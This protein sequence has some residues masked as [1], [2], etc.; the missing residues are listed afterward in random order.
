MARSS[1][2]RAQPAF[3]SW[4]GTVPYLTRAAIF[5]TLRSIATFATPGSKIVFDYGISDE[6]ID[7]NETRTIKKLTALTARRGE[8]V[9]T[10]FDPRTLPAE[11]CDLGFEL[12]EHLLPKEQRERYFANRKDDLQPL[13]SSFFAYFRVR[14]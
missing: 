9:I 12:V 11:V 10:R 1:Y 13:T 6:L 5:G 14:G 7:S 4:L 2:S 3:F 8:P